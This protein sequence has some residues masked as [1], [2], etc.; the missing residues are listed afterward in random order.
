VQFY[1]IRGKI[2][3]KPLLNKNTSR[4]LILSGIGMNENGKP[5]HTYIH[6]NIPSYKLNDHKKVK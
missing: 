5:A 6:A 2:G 4:S 1:K 3:K